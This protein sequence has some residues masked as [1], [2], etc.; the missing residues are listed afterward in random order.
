MRYNVIDFGAVGD[1]A[2]DDSESI[3]RAINAC[4]KR[5]GT[6]VFPSDHTFLSSSLLLKPGVE[7]HLEKGALLKATAI[8]TD[9]S[10]RLKP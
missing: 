2:A 3:Q 9:T 1:G 6:V 8:Y 5:G 7:L 10:D 4:G